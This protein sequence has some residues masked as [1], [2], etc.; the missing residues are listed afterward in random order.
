MPSI[1]FTN[2]ELAELGLYLD[3]I[4]RGIQNPVLQRA[5]GKITQKGVIAQMEIG[6]NR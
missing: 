1:S 2:H 5:M 4:V 3:E 6:R